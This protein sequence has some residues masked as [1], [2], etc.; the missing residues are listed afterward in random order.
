MS[1]DIE[2]DKINLYDPKFE[3]EKNAVL[4]ASNGVVLSKKNKS[5][6]FELNRLTIEALLMNQ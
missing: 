4:A 6:Y 1:Y 5:I 2:L 3:K